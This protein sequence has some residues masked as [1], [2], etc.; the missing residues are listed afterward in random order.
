MKTNTKRQLT[1]A[2]CLL[3]LTFVCAA[4]AAGSKSADEQTL[5]DLDAQWSAAAEAKDLD[6][7]V[8]YYSDNAI[9]LP[10]NAQIATT[11]DGIRNLWKDLFAI[12]GFALSWKT[13][14]VEVAKSGDMAY[15]TGTYQLTMNDSSGRPVNDHGKYLV[16]WEKQRDGKWKCVADTWNSDFPLPSPEKK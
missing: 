2:G 9:V 12:P 4:S 16:V 15:A 14:K 13:T 10:P 3:S 1:L 8:S 11:K 5:R 7:T 6:K